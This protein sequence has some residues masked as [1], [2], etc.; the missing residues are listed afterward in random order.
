MPLW[1]DVN[2]QVFGFQIN[3]YQQTSRMYDAEYFIVELSLRSAQAVDKLKTS[4]QFRNSWNGADNCG[5]CVTLKLV[6]TSNLLGNLN[7]RLG[8]CV[9][10]QTPQ[11]IGE[12]S[13]YQ[14][15]CGGLL[16]RWP[17]LKGLGSDGHRLVRGNTD[18]LEQWMGWDRGNR[19][20]V[21]G[22][23]TLC[24]KIC[25]AQMNI[26]EAT[27][28]PRSCIAAPTDKMVLVGSYFI[29]GRW[30][31]LGTLVAWGLL[32]HVLHILEGDTL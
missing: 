1:L 24:L 7:F 17:I 19:L 6:L 32:W 15:H 11:E 14:G 25:S 29:C 8:F 2:R 23:I 5:M 22:N 31:G 3:C 18:I 4:S 16:P 20:N 28:T 26:F 27:C 30:L 21:I 10:E 9:R 13:L 12:W